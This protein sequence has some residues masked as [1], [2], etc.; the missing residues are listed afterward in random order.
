MSKGPLSLGL[1]EGGRFDVFLPILHC[2]GTEPGLYGQKEMAVID[3]RFPLLPIVV[4]SFFFPEVAPDK[5]A[6]EE[7]E[8]SN[9]LVVLA[10]PHSPHIFSISSNLEILAVVIFIFCF[11]RKSI[12][13]KLIK[14][15]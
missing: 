14:M 3:C 12:T 4:A 1:D 9:Y 13:D 11:A 6:K 15:L 7:G 10:H 8:R 2:N 5:P